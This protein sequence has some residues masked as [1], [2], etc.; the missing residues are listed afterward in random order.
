MAQFIRKN[1]T[2]L[3]IAGDDKGKKGRVLMVNPQTGKVLV[4]GIS[5]IKRHMKP[6]QAVPQGGI[7]SREAWIHLS[8]VMLMTGDGP[9]RT[10]WMHSAD[11]KKVRRNHRTGEAID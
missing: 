6:S 11:G 7:V 4:E 9:V 1:D 10:S 8:N 3:V 5:I 2:V